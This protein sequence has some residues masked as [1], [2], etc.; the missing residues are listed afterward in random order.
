MAAR[1][2][3]LA[4][5]LSSVGKT[6]HWRSKAAKDLRSGCVMV[7][8]RVGRRLG[9][10]HGLG[11]GSESIRLSMASSIAIVVLEGVMRGS[12]LPGQEPGCEVGSMS[13]GSDVSISAM[14]VSVSVRPG[15]GF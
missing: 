5:L 15:V 6:F 12:I 11:C 7:L 13:V 8:R 4:A 3:C 10:S 2:V 9:A 1:K 14:V